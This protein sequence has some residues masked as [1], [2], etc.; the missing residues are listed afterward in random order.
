MKYKI[1]DK[2]ILKDGESKILDISNKVVEIGDI[3]N[4]SSGFIVYVLLDSK[5]CIIEE[6]IA[7]LYI[8]PVPINNRFEILDIRD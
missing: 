3:I 7:D 6:Q 8:Y 4:F 5:I 2:V 1:G